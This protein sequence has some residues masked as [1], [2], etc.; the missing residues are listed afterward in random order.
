MKQP[1]RICIFPKDIQMITGR[2]PRYGS[3]VINEIKTKLNKEPHQFVTIHEF[4]DYSGLD[5]ELIKSFIKD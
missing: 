4:A 2:S 1:K 5:V 3:K